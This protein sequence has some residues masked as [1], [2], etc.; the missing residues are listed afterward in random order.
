LFL[1]HRLERRPAER[2]SALLGGD[3]VAVVVVVVLLLGPVPLLAHC[4][5]GRLSTSKLTLENLDPTAALG[6]A[7]SLAD[8]NRITLFLFTLVWGI[9]MLLS[10]F[11]FCVGLVPARA[12]YELALTEA[13][14]LATHDDLAESALRQPR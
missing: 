1:D 5:L 8:G 14:L 2:K 12:A 9:A 10:V 11:A 4:S 6:R 7:W 13:F 3:K